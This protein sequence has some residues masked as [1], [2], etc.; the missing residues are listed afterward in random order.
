MKLKAIIQR[1]EQ[2][3]EDKPELRDSDEKLISNIWYD[4]LKSKNIKVSEG[5]YLHFL[6]MYG[7]GQLTSAESIRRSRAK[8]QEENPHLRGKSYQ[9]RQTELQAETIKEL[10]S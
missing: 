4:D 6:R 2:W 9:R 8:L 5:S 3:F 10:F 7:T 1:V